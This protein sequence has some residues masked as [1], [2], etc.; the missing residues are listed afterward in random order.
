MLL[1][2]DDWWAILPTHLSSHKKKN[3]NEED[4][5]YASDVQLTLT[6]TV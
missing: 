5:K 1:K 4:I 6:G 2:Y 3:C